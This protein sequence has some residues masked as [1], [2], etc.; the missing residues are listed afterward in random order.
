MDANLSLGSGASG[1]HDG[2]MAP[3]DRS[4]PLVPDLGAERAVYCNRTVNL[5]TIRAIGYD[6]DY[7]LVHY[8]P[9]EWEGA[10][11][12]RAQELLA[13]RGWPVD[14]FAFDPEA[15]TQGL[16]FDLELGNIVKATRFG[17]VIRAQHG[18]RPL[19]FEETRRAYA[20]AVVDLAEDRFQF[21]NTMFSLSQASLFAQLVDLLD[22]GVVDRGM[23]EGGAGRRVAGTA[24]GYP[25]VW[26]LLGEVLEESHTQGELKARI[27][28]DPDRFVVRDPDLVSTLADQ[29]DAGKRL[30]VITNSDWL[31]T[32]A[33]L[34][35]ALGPFLPA[36]TAWR[37]LFHLV[38]VDADK[39]RF[40][41]ERRPVYD[42]VDAAEPDARGP[43]LARRRALLE[44]GGVYS[45]GDAALVEASLGLS[46]A[47][48]LY[49]GDHLFGD[50]HVTKAMLR[51]RTGLVLRELEEE[52]AAQVAFRDTERELNRLMAEKAL[53][54]RE[55][56]LAR[57][58][59]LR[60]RRR[61]TADG[62]GGPSAAALTGRINRATRRS[63]EL[64]ARLAPLA[65]AAGRVANERW[66]L[67]MRAGNDRSLFARQVERY[68][69][70]YTSRVSNLGAETP[71][72]Y[73]RARRT[74]LPHDP[75]A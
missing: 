4:E 39:P 48:L 37:D 16:V 28:A 35:H 60:R 3:T 14:G 22:K 20:D 42:V 51:W 61:G 19:A 49:V 32:R 30:C 1:E 38:V 6:L 27:R 40:F 62:G 59:R 74:N 47:E 33:M 63:G 2:G 17:Y 5:R 50:V 72:A 46:G 31:Y 44:A 68:A 24:A 10:A 29:R 69:D 41:S 52:L 53:L 56:A 66:G 75:D 36:G 18:T 7:T 8:R 12:A 15:Y 55:L 65:E 64:D 13:A 43:L 71:Y 26:R 45:G 23:V 70:L 21:M 25:D 58:A 73:L 54:D 57:L 67:L 9:S 34:E 11:F